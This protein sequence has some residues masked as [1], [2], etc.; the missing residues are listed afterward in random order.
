MFGP[1]SFEDTK[2]RNQQESQLTKCF[3]C[4]KEYNLRT[5]MVLFCKHLFEEHSLIIEDVQN[6]PNLPE[7][8]LNLCRLILD[9]NLYI[10]D[11]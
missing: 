7:Y 2:R 9:Y 10:L 4:S 5:D 6:I 8:I 3:L 11:T 1:L